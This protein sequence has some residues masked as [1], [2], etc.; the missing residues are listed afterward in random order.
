MNH[1]MPADEQ[2][3]RALFGG[4]PTPR[5]LL[6]G[7]LLLFFV[8]LLF[9]AALVYILGTLADAIVDPTPEAS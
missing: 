5:G 8:A 4:H 7:K 6:V 1:N 3:V 9:L 2:L